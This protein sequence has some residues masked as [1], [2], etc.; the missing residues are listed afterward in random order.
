MPKSNDYQI[1]AV[2]D[3][4]LRSK[5]GVLNP[6]SSEIEDFFR[7]AAFV[8]ANLETVLTDEG[9][10]LKK[11]VVLQAS[12]SSADY[13]RR[14][15]I[16][17]VNLANNHALDYGI[18]GFTSTIATLDKLGV[19]HFGVLDHGEQQPYI[20]STNTNRIGIL[21]YT[22]GARPDTMLGVAILDK[23]KIWKDIVNLK[24]HK[25]DKIIVNLHWGEEYVAYP[26][27][28]QQNLARG[29]VDQGVDVIIGHHPHVVQGIEKYKDGVIFY[30]LGN[31]NFLNSRNIDQ[32]F[33]G[34]QWGLIILLNF[35]P[36]LPIEYE[37]VP[38][39]IDSEY[40][41]SFPSPETKA[42]FINYVNCISFPLE[43]GIKQSFWLREASWPRFRNNLSSFFL[44]IR[45][46][47]IFH[48]YQMIRWLINPTNFVYYLGLILKIIPLSMHKGFPPSCSVPKG[49]D[50]D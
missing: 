26:S 43:A 2:G 10:S 22:I 29:M 23:Q 38:V 30:S 27:P 15:G 42:A 8:M 4:L 19:N 25:V 1:V 3:V 11:S 16:D 18:M 33:P 35:P 41:P 32:L 49:C 45:M 7:N 14:T 40:R 48:L 46:Y 44:R 31:F 50:A 21:G 20:L 39:W 37:C 28:E 12:P 34:T 13:L 17:A 24:L 9:N 6:F 47:G 36:S 5:S